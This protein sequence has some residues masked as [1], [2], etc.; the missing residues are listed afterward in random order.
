MQ[1]W[2]SSVVNEVETADSVNR[3]DNSKV[4]AVYY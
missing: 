4:H 3:N 2:A 1:S